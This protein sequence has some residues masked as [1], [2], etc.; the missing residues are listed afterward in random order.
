MAIFEVPP[1]TLVFLSGMLSALTP[2]ILPILP[3]ILAG[4]KGHKLRPV[5]ILAGATLSF[6]F[7]G[8]IFAAVGSFYAREY[9]RYFFIGMLILFGTAYADKNANAIYTKY[10]SLFINRISQSL[11]LAGTGGEGFD[12]RSEHPLCSAFFLAPRSE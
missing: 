5:F 1:V 2:C 12:K 6:T 7:M 8:G 3:P 9:L 10:S 4:S 11:K